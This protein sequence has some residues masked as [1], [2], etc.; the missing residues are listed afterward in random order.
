[1]SQSASSPSPYLVHGN[2]YSSTCPIFSFC[3]AF[4]PFLSCVSFAPSFFL[5]VFLE[6]FF[7]LCFPSRSLLVAA[8]YHNT[9]ALVLL[10]FFVFFFSFYS[11]FWLRS[12]S[13]ACLGSEISHSSNHTHRMY[14]CIYICTQRSFP[15]Y[16]PGVHFRRS[17]WQ[18]NK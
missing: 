11:L 8:K 16:S 2:A 6:V 5:G 9:L 7:P 15:S 18:S 13:F 3:D 4:S 14:E 1:M 12:S 17:R 10:V